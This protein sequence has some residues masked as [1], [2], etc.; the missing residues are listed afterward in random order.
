MMTTSTAV[1]V[2]RIQRDRPVH[3]SELIRHLLP[4]YR[5]IDAESRHVPVTTNTSRR[6]VTVNHS[7][8]VEFRP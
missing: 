3:I 4:E 2:V 8:Q 7:T 1:T 5:E 6:P